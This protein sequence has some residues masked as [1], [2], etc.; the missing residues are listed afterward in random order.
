MSVRNSLRGFP[1]TNHLPGGG[2]GLLGQG[3]DR[4]ALNRYPALHGRGRGAVHSPVTPTRDPASESLTHIV[5][6]VVAAEP[7][8][9]V[10]IGDNP[11][12]DNGPPAM[13]VKTYRERHAELRPDPK[14]RA[15]HE[16][17]G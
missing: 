5:D 2:R 13:D 12:T 11:Y 17:C 7:E 10:S 14:A 8:L 15:L 16:Q 1:P 3:F 9:Y 6:H 4:R